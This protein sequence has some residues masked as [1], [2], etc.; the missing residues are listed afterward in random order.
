ML[1]YKQFN[2]NFMANGQ[3]NS[4]KNNINLSRYETDVEG[5]SLNKLE[6][7]LWWT[8]NRKNL[9]SFLV[10]VLLAVSLVGWGYTFYGFGNYLFFGMNQDE[11]TIKALVRSET[12]G[13]DYLDQNAAKKLSY[14]SVGVVANE[15]KYDLYALVKNINSDHWGEFSYCFIAGSGE[16]TCGNDFIL[17]GESKYILSLAKEFSKLPSSVSFLPSNDVWHRIDRHVIPNWRA[18]RSERLDISIK[19]QVFTPASSNE[20]SEKVA[21]NALS[22]SIANDGAFG[23]HTLPL[24]IVLFS[25]SRVASVNRYVVTDFPSYDQ[26]E[27]KIIWPGSIGSVNNISIV[28]DINIA[29]QGVFEKPNE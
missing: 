18:Y 5:V 23:Y 4:N 19:N 20:L 16:K 22:F 13:K 25:G 7:G 26:R 24:T 15:G 3:M 2:F 1:K 14:S 6:A 28:P 10:F 27:I 11:Q 21:L 17:P 9:K 12:V 29:D 8:K